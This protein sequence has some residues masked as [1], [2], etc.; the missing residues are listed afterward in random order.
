MYVI[1]HIICNHPFTSKGKKLPCAAGSLAVG[2][3]CCES[4]HGAPS[5]DTP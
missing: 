1:A 3:A 2:W 5:G 4:G